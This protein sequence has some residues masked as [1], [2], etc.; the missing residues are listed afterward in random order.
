M[1]IVNLNF[2]K[3]LSR[4]EMRGIAGGNVR[5]VLTDGESYPCGHDDLDLCG[6]Q[7]GDAF[8]DECG[9]CYGGID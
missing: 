5:C 1:D 8:G 6:S 3:T 4:E 2:G 7:C 9:G